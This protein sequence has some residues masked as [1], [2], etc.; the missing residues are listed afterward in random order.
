MMKLGK[1]IKHRKEIEIRFDDNSGRAGIVYLDRDEKE[2]RFENR[3]DLDEEECLSI[4]NILR[5][6]NKELKKQKGDL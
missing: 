3:F 6:L 4:H 5:K 2:Y 1:A